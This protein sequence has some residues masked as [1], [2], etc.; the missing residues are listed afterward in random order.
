M[1]NFG[2]TRN[3]VQEKIV[4]LVYSF[5]IYQDSKTDL[6]F[7]AVVSEVCGMPYEDCDIFL[8]EVLIKV[9]KN[10]KLIVSYVNKYLKN[11]NFYR[12]NT[13]VQAILLA[14]I[15]EFYLDKDMDKAVIINNAVKF[16]KKFGDGGLKDYKF[17]NA[18]LQNCLDDGRENLLLN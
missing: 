7:E 11:W 8:K 3:Q 13:T 10:Q 5:L 12:L 2:L 1:E 17:V 4:Q 9:L 18:V 15:V 16:S 6:N 14:S